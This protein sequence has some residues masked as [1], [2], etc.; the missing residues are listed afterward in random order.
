MAAKTPYRTRSKD[1][2]CGLFGAALFWLPT[3]VAWPDSHTRELDLALY[4]LLSCGI[5]FPLG[6]W[7]MRWIGRRLGYGQNGLAAGGAALAGIDLGFVVL[8]LV[9][10]FGDS[11]PSGAAS[12]GF[13]LYWLALGSV[14]GLF[15]CPGLVALH[16]AHIL[17][18]VFAGDR[19]ELGEVPPVPS[20]PFPIAKLFF[21]FRAGGRFLLCVAIGAA[22][23]WGLP[24][25]VNEA[26]PAG[27]WTWL[28]AAAVSIG[29]SMPL[30]FRATV[31]MQL[32]YRDRIAPAGVI[33]GVL[34]G[35]NMAPMWWMA[36][37]SSAPVD[38]ATLFHPCAIIISIFPLGPIASTYVGNA[39]LLLA[40]NLFGL[41]ALPQALFTGNRLRPMPT[42]GCLG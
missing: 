24:L 11:G 40:V 33:G 16:F 42:H 30:L 2:L 4:L 20:R 27:P 22:F 15:L 8:V 12:F 13:V 6:H 3:L 23:V 9:W 28:A 38:L 34:L 25:L 36:L 5:G 35:A 37:S 41:V 14:A 29:I 26:L 19:R 32:R 39:P 21:P 17:Q 10:I 7:G 31:R 1:L 18:T